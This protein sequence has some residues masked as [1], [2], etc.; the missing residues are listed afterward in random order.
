MGLTHT[1]RLVLVGSL[2]NQTQHIRPVLTQCTQD[3]LLQAPVAT[4]ERLSVVLLG[5]PKLLPT[6]AKGLHRCIFRL[7][8]NDFE[9]EQNHG[10]IV[11]SGLASAGC[12]ERG[13]QTER[14]YSQLISETGR[15]EEK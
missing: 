4:L 7:L 15:M 1:V 10:P 3:K 5:N 11:A 6:F 8:S 2:G 14:E 13:A 12:L 9:T